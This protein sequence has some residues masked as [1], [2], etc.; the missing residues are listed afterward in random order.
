M[1]GVTTNFSHRAAKSVGNIPMHVAHASGARSKQLSQKMYQDI[2]VIFASKPMWRNML[3]Y[4]TITNN[5]A[6][7]INYFNC[8]LKN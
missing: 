5:P 6:A 2:S 3:F 8:N 7:Q 4:Q 1:I